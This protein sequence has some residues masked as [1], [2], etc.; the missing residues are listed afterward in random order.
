MQPEMLVSQNHLQST[1]INKSYL[2]YIYNEGLLNFR[3]YKS[4]VVITCLKGLAPFVRKEVEALGYHITSEWVTGIQLKASMADCIRLNLRLRCASQVL[5]EIA[6]FDANDIEHVSSMMKKIP[7]EDL[8]PSDG[9]V[10]VTNSARH[11]SINNTMFANQFVKDIICDRI[12]ENTDN[13]PDAGPKQDYSVVNWVWINNQVSVFLDTSGNSLGK[14]GYRLF[15]GKAPLGEAV[16]AAIVYASEWDCS[17]TLLNP[18]CGSGTLA[19]EAAMI[20][21]KRYPGLNRNNY[22]FMHFLGYQ[23]GFYESELE[24]IRNIVDLQAKKCIIASDIDSEAIDIAMSNAE[25]AGVRHLISF[26]KGDFM[27]SPVPEAENGIVLFNP[28]YGERLGEAEDLKFLYASIGDFLKKRCKGYKAFVLSGNPDL[29][30]FIGL[31]TFLKLQLYAGKIEC[32]L[33]GF[34]MY[35]GKKNQDEV[36]IN[37]ES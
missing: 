15:P 3:S 29:M 28:P 18:M 24:E 8:I 7:W 32:K 33:H 21:S 34:K 16:S 5:F 12:K 20:Q 10:S 31:Q 27:Q 26:G 19:I 9:Y 22:A 13:R 6:A 1:R 23:K 37:E 30:K 36:T 2:N 17:S 4:Y 25:K 11:D 14:H 35:A